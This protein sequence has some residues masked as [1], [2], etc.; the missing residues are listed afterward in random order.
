MKR[1]LILFVLSFTVFFSYTVVAQNWQMRN[2]NFP[3][4]V[5]IVD[6]SSVNSQVCWAVGQIYPGN[7]APYSG[8][9]KTID[10]GENWILS[11]IP[12][13]PDG[14]FQ[15]IF[16]IDADTAYITIYIFSNQNSKN[17][18]KTTNKKTT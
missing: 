9:I 13:I 11:S 1:L 14:F 8:Y 7:N 5:L 6:F 16:A 2:S 4:N 10:G 18:Y 12:G 17:I 3:S 15:Q